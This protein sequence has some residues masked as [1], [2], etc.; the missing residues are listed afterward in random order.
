MLKLV[1]A[2]EDEH[3]ITKERRVTLIV[4]I[5]LVGITC[6]VRS[7]ICERSNALAIALQEADANY[8]CYEFREGLVS[9]TGRIG[10]IRI[11]KSLQYIMRCCLI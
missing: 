6:A 1:A 10:R 3:N 4:G 2:L 8:L 7:A 9:H 5:D 11:D